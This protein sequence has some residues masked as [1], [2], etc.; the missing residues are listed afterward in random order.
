VTVQQIYNNNI[1]ENY[2][3]YTETYAILSELI[4]W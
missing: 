3:K 2:D 1:C 4:N